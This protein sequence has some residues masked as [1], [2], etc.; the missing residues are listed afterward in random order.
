VHAKPTPCRPDGVC[1]NYLGVTRAQLRIPDELHELS[2]SR[3]E[4]SVRILIEPDGAIRSI[5]PAS[6]SNKVFAEAAVKSL[7]GLR[8]IGQGRVVT[9]L[10]PFVLTID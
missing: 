5:E 4:A 9:L 3:F 7:Q 10:A 1:P 8:C 6:Y 2:E